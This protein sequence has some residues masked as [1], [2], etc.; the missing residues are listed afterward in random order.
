MQDYGSVNEG[1]EGLV[2]DS[3]FAVCTV[4]GSGNH[5]FLSVSLSISLMLLAWSPHFFNDSFLSIFLIPAIAGSFRPFSKASRSSPVFWPVRFFVCSHI[6]LP[7]SLIWAKLYILENFWT[8]LDSAPKLFSLGKSS[9]LFEV[10]GYVREELR[11]EGNWTPASLILNLRT[12]RGLSLTKTVYLI[13]F[14]LSVDL[15]I[16]RVTW[17]LHFSTWICC[18]HL[19]FYLVISRGDKCLWQI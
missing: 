4:G 16:C 12:R 19:L 9:G 8:V 6:P 18:H 17:T 11:S 15:D 2:L 14:V 7:S 13:S 5:Q 1:R 10:G 3:S